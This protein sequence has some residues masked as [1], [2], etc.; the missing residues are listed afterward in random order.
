MI[1]KVT[2]L[3]SI[4]PKFVEKILNGEKCFEYRKRIPEHS[5]DKLIIYSS[6]PVCKVVGEAEIEKI[7][8][9]TPENIWHITKYQSGIG[10][11]FFFEYFKDKKVAYAYKLK[12]IKKYFPPRKLSDYGLKTAPQSFSYIK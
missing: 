7:L 2:I 6:S 5:I 10:S 4:K 12:N 11:E 1:K 9:D 3:L 8:F